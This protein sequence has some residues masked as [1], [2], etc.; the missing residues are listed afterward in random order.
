M[1]PSQKIKMKKIVPLVGFQNSGKTSF[2]N[3]IYNLNYKMSEDSIS[4]K[5]INI[6]RYNPEINEPKFF[7]LIVKSK[8]ETYIFE[9]DEQYQ[10]I[11]GVENIKNEIKRINEYLTNKEQKIEYKNNFYM[12]EINEIAFGENNDN[13]MFFLEYD[14]CDTPGMSL[15]QI[16]N[17][18]NTN[19]YDEEDETKYQ[20]KENSFINEIFEIIK[21]DIENFII[22]L[23]R[24]NCNRGTIKEIIA[25]LRKV[26]NKKEIANCLIL[27]NKID[28]SN[29][30]DEVIN[31]CNIAFCKCFPKYK[32]FN[33]NLNTFIPFSAHQLIL[34]KDFKEF[35]RNIYINKPQIETSFIDHIRNEVFSDAIKD[36][37]DENKNNLKND[38]ENINNEEIINILKELKD[39][40]NINLEIKIK[41]ESNVEDND[42]EEKDLFD[43]NDDSE[44]D[45]NFSD[46]DIIKILKIYYDKKELNF[47]YPEVT[48]KLID[49]FKI[50]KTSGNTK[51]ESQ[52]KNDD[53]NNKGKIIINN[54]NNIIKRFEEIENSKSKLKNTFMGFKSDINYLT[55][56][57]NSRIFLPFLGPSNSGKSTILNAIIGKDLL[58]VE[59]REC[60]KK[61]IIISYSN[62]NDPDIGIKNAKLKTQI[63]EG[64][65]KYY[66]EFEEKYI[67][68]DLE[69]VKNTLKYQNSYYAYKNF[70]NNSFYYIRT[71]IKLF[72]EIPLSNYLKKKLFLIDLPG[73]GA[74]NTFNFDKVIKISDSF[75]INVNNSIINEKENYS[76]FEKI[77]K[78]KGKFA[79]GIIK[80]CLFIC[81][82]KSNAQTQDE[83]DIIKAKEEIMKL[84]KVKNSEDI[85]VCFCNGKKY[86]N[87][88]NNKN[89]FFD[90]KQT[91]KDE[92]MNYYKW[93]RYSFRKTNFEEFFKKAVKK[94]Y[95]SLQLNKNS[96][97]NKNECLTTDKIKK[98]INEFPNVKISENIQCDL[99]QKFCD[100]QKKLII[101]KEAKIE[102]LKNELSKVINNNY[103]ELN[104]I[105]KEKIKKQI[106]C[107]NKI[108]KEEFP[109]D[110]NNY[111]FNELDK[112]EDDIIKEIKQLIEES[113]KRSENYNKLC[114][115]IVINYLVEKKGEIEKLLKKNN[116]K[117]VKE[118][119]IK[120]LKEYL[121]N[122][123]RSIEEYLD[124]INEKS[125]NMKEIRKKI[126]NDDKPI[127]DFKEYFKRRVSSKN[128]NITDE[129]MNEIEKCFGDTMIMIFK[130]KEMGSFLDS[131]TN[132]KNYLYNFIDIVS[133]SYKYK[134]NAIIELI[135]DNFKEFM[136]EEIN[137]I[138]QTMD[139]YSVK[140]LKFS[141][142][143][144]E[145]LKNFCE[146]KIKEIEKI[147]NEIY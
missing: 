100:S 54:L 12:T 117:L 118:E 72:D 29:N 134:L 94:K 38:C 112:M 24:N 17:E 137:L 121:N 55:N 35:L 40:Y 53:D 57:N 108:L 115:I 34:N 143:E 1:N 39:K 64:E 83:K 122:V 62:D 50:N 139:I 48:K 91:I 51:K 73:Y 128:A 98:I 30:T 123:C 80:N 70:D 92:F 7:H 96:D 37:I 106:N 104:E 133:N 109:E 132:N 140:F 84:T 95:E 68:C 71:K 63:I 110:L 41:E 138:T 18:E 103:N 85:N 76:I 8:G 82:V 26:N 15:N 116:W 120:E 61:G 144:K 101:P 27:L 9:K 111:S 56:P 20:T 60:T 114:E 105:K 47:E 74:E 107:F 44:Q 93:K 3:I 88:I 10:E 113:V 58:P 65:E 33:I 45:D 46:L 13:K 49:Y 141:P 97:N 124:S 135:R 21:N 6:Y 28:E 131:I 89:Y 4:T 81:N 125:L 23:D 16:N 102:N 5:F 99:A 31:N 145:E 90:I 2:L 75:V 66:F 36:E 67:T 136:N 127:E 126:F 147:L 43:N 86:L 77:L 79:N 11:S 59:S 14:L 42:N 119:I 32:A 87:Y 129:I 142:Q 69:Q 25:H 146:P 130:Q 52:E 78:N 22:M 19:F